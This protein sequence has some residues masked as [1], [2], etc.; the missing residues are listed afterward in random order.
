MSRVLGAA[1]TLP[2]LGRDF[3]AGI[4]EAE[5]RYLVESEWA[6][7]AQDILW[8]RSRLGLRLDASAVHHLQ[9]AV[10]KLL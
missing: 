6:R 8:R 4:T 7:S 5:V 2:E 1:R 10:A 3:G 9:D